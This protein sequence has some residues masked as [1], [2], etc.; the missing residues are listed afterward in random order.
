MIAASFWSLLAPSIDLSFELG[1]IAWILPATGFIVGGLFVLLSDRFLDTV[2]KNKKN[3]K[4]Q[5]R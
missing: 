5:I 1:Y 4:V 2:L 3:L